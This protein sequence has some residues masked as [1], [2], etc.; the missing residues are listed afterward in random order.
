MSL[1]IENLFE[2]V[3][4]LP[5]DARLILVERL[6]ASLNLPTQEEIDRLW[7][8]EAERRVSEIDQ[9]EVDLIPGEKVFER[10]RKKYGQ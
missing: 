3:L 9:G 4:S 10:I 6:L 2:E 7:A 5:A 8:D 1:S